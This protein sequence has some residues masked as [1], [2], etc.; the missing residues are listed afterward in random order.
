MKAVLNKETNN[1]DLTFTAELTITRLRLE[2]IL[3]EMVEHSPDLQ[4]TRK[5]VLEA[6]TEKIRTHGTQWRSAK[7]MLYTST[8]VKARRWALALFPELTHMM[9]IQH[10]TDDEYGE[11]HN[12]HLPKFTSQDGN[13]WV[14]AN[15]MVYNVHKCQSAPDDDT[16]PTYYYRIQRAVDPH[17]HL[18]VNEQAVVLHFF[19]KGYINEG[20]V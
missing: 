4:P 16:R 15:K 1:I 6:L 10:G 11:L 12:T 20:G 18:A 5:H 8:V 13:L 9:E 17:G 2:D 14:C 3:C 7:H 19:Q